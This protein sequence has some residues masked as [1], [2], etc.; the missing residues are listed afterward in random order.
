MILSNENFHSGR[1]VLLLIGT[2]L[3]MFAQ[4]QTALGEIVVAK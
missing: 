1:S 2:L 3:D 4:W